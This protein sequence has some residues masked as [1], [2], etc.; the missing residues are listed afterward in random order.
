MDPSIFHRPPTAL[1]QAALLGL[2]LCLPTVRAATLHFEA[3]VH[4]AQ[5]QFQQQPYSCELSHVIPGFGEAHFRRDSLSEVGFTLQVEEALKRGGTATMIAE[6]PAWQP[7]LENEDLGNVPLRP[8]ATPLQLGR[9]PSLRML[10]ELER[11]MQVRL[12]APNWDAIPT[13]VSITLSTVNI[14]TP[15]VQ[16]RQCLAS[17]P[18]FD[19]VRLDDSHILFAT[20]SA[21]LDT[22]ARAWLD[23]LSDYLKLNRHPPVVH[24]E[25]HTD[26]VATRRYNQRLAQRRAEAVRAYLLGKGVPADVIRLQ[27]FGESRPAASNRT[28]QGRQQNRRVRI[29]V[30]TKA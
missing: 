28:E 18:V 13:P 14:R 4:Q 11:G 21:K 8:G 2:L 29:R 15:L 30:E 16:F 17:L 6:P 7:D 22:A 24:V 1:A 19:R 25:A 10:S 20:D 3:P 23:K 12:H 27:A 5:W 26:N 9:E